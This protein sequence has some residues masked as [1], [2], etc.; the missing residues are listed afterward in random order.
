MFRYELIQISNKPNV[1]KSALNQIP[2]PKFMPK[3]DPHIKAKV[4][5]K[6]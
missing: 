1:S 6:D 4:Q 5:G 2:N 3:I